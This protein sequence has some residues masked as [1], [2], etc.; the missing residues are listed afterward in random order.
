MSS[1]RQSAASGHGLPPLG[2]IAALAAVLASLGG[3]A[4]P[5]TKAGPIET[6]V[7]AAPTPPVTVPIPPAALAT[8]EERWG[9]QVTGIRLSAAGYMLDFR[10]RV[11]DAGKAS[12][13]LNRRVKPYLIVDSN[14]AKLM[15][16]NTPKLG[17]L[18]QVASGANPDRTN[19]ML[20]ANPGKAVQSGSKVTLVMGDLKVEDIVVQ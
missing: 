17:L 2:A 7:A 12:P 14:G 10:Y 1:G 9:I 15:V 8:P 4:I 16:P 5:A 20:F 18:R 6:A 13:V 19:F 3:C 11:L